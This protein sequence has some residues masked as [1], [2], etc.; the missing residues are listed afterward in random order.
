MRVFMRVN[1]PAEA[2]NK[3]IKDGSL[4]KIVEAFMA[5][6][7]PES[8]HFGVESGERTM[9][10]VFDLASPAEIPVICEPLFQGFGATIHFQPVMDL[11]D[12]QKGLASL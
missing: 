6:T 8:A 3:A 7:K 11:A 12:L 10:V 1:I 5:K 2:G 9:F 4:G